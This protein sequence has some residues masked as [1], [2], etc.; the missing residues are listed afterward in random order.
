MERI[1]YQDD[2]V[3]IEIGRSAEDHEIFIKDGEEYISYILPRG[4]L[5]EYSKEKP[6][7]VLSAINNFNSTLVNHLFE[8]KISSE[9]LTRILAQ[10]Q[11]KN[12]E[13]ERDYFI[14][15]YNKEKS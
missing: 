8:Q 10:A 15:K 6:E 9:N 13:K 5:E 11:I 14:D 2:L 3:K 7:R 12:I 1:L 4:F